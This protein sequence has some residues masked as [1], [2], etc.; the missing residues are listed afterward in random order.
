MCVVVGGGLFLCVDVFIL[1]IVAVS[2]NPG[3]VLE[4]A[5]V[6]TPE[7]RPG[8]EVMLVDGTSSAEMSSDSTVT[9]GPPQQ[10]QDD[11]IDIAGQFLIRKISIFC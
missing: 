5:G 3:V 8:V 9:A 7:P 1:W 6:G 4:S 11:T 10:G 2:E